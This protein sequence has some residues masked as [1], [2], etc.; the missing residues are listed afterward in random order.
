MSRILYVIIAILSFILI[1]FLVLIF[2]SIR[3]LNS[4]LVTPIAIS[5]TINTQNKDINTSQIISLKDAV[6]ASLSGSKGTYAVFIKNLKTNEVY[7]LNQTKKFAA[8]SLYKLWIMAVT[9]QQIEQGKISPDDILS[10]DVADL[11]ERFDIAT[12]S[13]ELT[14]GTISMSISD[15]LEKMITI[16]DNYSALLLSAKI[17]FSNVIQFLKDEG[18]QDSSI[19]E[20]PMTTVQDLGLFLEKLYHKELISQNSSNKMLNLLKNQQKNNKLPKYLPENITIAHKTGEI[21]TFTHDAGIVYIPN[22][23]YIIIVMS[24]TDDPKTAEETIAKISQSIYNIFN[25]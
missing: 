24:D 2:F 10:A 6:D 11:N 20:P 19:G 23:D 16:S 21:D 25:P 12:E 14:E 1:T 4:Q 5:P 8:G 9:Y 3:S 17:R 15:A 7:Q 22:N 13:A 18:F